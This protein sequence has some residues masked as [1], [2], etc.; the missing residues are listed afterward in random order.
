MDMAQ[1]ITV[2]LT[3]GIGLWILQTISKAVS[4]VLRARG[5]IRSE[6]DALVL[7]RSQ[8]IERYSALR[9][10]YARGDEIPDLVTGDEYDDWLEE[11]SKPHND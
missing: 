3:G 4:Q 7:S 1:F 10:A 9:N 11:H 6:K 8:W 5:K 2:L